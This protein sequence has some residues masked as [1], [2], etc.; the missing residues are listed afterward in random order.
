MIT[1]NKS[2][3]FFLNKL[4]WDNFRK[5]KKRRKDKNEM[6]SRIQSQTPIVKQ[7][8]YQRY[9]PNDGTSLIRVTTVFCS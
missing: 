1:Y 7:A 9:I 6:I 2:V 5:N 4:A 3:C 8:E